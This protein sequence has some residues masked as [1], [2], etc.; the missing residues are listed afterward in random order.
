MLEPG[1][2]ALDYG[3]GARQARSRASARRISG[4][5][6]AKVYKVREYR[7]RFFYLLEP[8]AIQIAR[9][10]AAGSHGRPRRCS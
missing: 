1:E 7:E 8:S 5:D 10:S 2:D 9:G 3:R 6:L 4:T